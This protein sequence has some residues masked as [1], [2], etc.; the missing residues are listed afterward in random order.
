[1]TFTPETIQRQVD[2]ARE[3]RDGLRLV[4]DVGP[5]TAWALGLLLILAGLLIVFTGRDAPARHRNRPL[6]TEENPR[7]REAV[8]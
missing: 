6:T 2:D 8:G 3:S 7:E 1:M 5:K 4:K